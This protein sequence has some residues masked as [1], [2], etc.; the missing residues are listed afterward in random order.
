MTSVIENDETLP[1][2]DDLQPYL[3][4]IED[5]TSTLPNGLIHKIALAIPDLVY[6]LNLSDMRVIYVSPSVTELLGYTFEDVPGLTGNIS[7]LIHPDDAPAY[8]EQIESIRQSQGEARFE[9]E[10]RVRHKNGDWRWFQTHTTVFER[11]EQGHPRQML[12][13][14][15]DV[16]EHKRLEQVAL[17]HTLEKERIRLL[18]EFIGVTSHELMTPL[19]TMNTGLYLLERTPDPHKQQERIK[20][21]QHQV[22]HLTRL[23]QDMQMMVRLD[24]GYEVHFASIHPNNV[25]EMAV[26]RLNKAI[27]EKSLSLRLELQEDIPTVLGDQEKMVQAVSNILEN[28]ARYTPPGG[29][30][31][32]RSAAAGASV[33]IEVQ[34]TGMGIAPDEIPHIFEHFYKTDKARTTNISGTGLGLTIAQRIIELHHGSIQVESAVGR[35][36]LFRIHLPLARSTAHI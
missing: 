30:I 2:R 13:I 17:S 32:L 1:S 35:G 22:E 11:D 16:S 36:S 19:T 24:T 4:P 3:E 20:N 23:I 5:E 9:Y 21:I 7:R 8:A 33:S 6:L 31:T 34:D 29:S 28:A 12:G 26:E 14:S 25:I 27:F 15:R 18:G 10:Y